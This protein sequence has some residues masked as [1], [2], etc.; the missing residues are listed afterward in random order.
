MNNISVNNDSDNHMTFSCD[1]DNN[2]GTVNST[3]S[4]NNS[5][6]DNNYDNNMTLSCN[7]RSI[8][9]ILM[10]TIPRIMLRR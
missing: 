2:H 7:N 10:S 9:D 4:T 3:T 8:V 5:M 1:N 6:N